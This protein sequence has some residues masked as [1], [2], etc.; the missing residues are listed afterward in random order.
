MQVTL[1]ATILGRSVGFWF[2]WLSVL[3]ML[4]VI[5]CHG[6]RDGHHAECFGLEELH[7]CPN[8]FF[9]QLCDL[10]FCAVRWP[11][12]PNL[13]FAPTITCFPLTKP[14][15]DPILTTNRY[16]N[17]GM[18]KDSQIV[19]SSHN[20]VI[21]ER[22]KARHIMATWGYVRSQ[23]LGYRDSDG[24]S[25]VWLVYFVKLMYSKDETICWFEL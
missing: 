2:Y 9:H 15:E 4:R 8:V 14:K 19:F 1:A 7:R 20:K 16:G 24:K 17:I 18:E 23:K 3:R 25:I 12:L 21:R 5:D 13:L 22:N 11:L 10:S 6:E